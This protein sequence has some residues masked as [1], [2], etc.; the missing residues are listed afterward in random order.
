M[1]EHVNLRPVQGTEARLTCYVRLS[2]VTLRHGTGGWHAEGM[3]EKAPNQVAHSIARLDA[4]DMGLGM[5][6]VPASHKAALDDADL[7]CVHIAR[8]GLGG[9]GCVRV[10]KYFYTDEQK[11][12]VCQACSQAIGA[13]KA[14]GAGLQ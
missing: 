9:G 2:S 13:N 5:Y 12:A 3:A 11:L 1:Q 7:A 10:V 14:A 4:P 6:L 8:K